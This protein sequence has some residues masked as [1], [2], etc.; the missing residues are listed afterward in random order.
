M[1]AA[2]KIDIPWLILHGDDDVNVSFSVAQQ[3][4]QKQLKA[5]ILKIE[6][7]NHVYG[8]SH[9]YTSAS[10]PEHLQQVVENTFRFISL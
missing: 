4:A 8:A 10:L 9:P 5:K 2:K 1:S 6:G 7:A 3:L